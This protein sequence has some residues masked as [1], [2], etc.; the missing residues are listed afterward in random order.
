M[1]KGLSLILVI[2][3][4]SIVLIMTA[5]TIMFYVSYVPSQS[6]DRLY[7]EENKLKACLEVCRKAQRC[8]ED[9]KRKIQPPTL[10]L[11]ERECSGYS[12]C[13]LTE[14]EKK[15]LEK[16]KKPSGESKLTPVPG[17]CFG[18]ENFEKF[19]SILSSD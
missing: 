19:K 16:L 17:P 10:E 18:K 7:S 5:V 12:A 11:I 6:M 14:E 9:K 15:R 1:E 8:R 4:T 13:E 2:L 3:V